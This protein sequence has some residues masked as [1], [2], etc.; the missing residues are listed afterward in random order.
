MA[1]LQCICRSPYFAICDVAHPHPACDL[2]LTHASKTCS[3]VL[4]PKPVWCGLV[5]KCSSYVRHLKQSLAYAGRNTRDVECKHKWHAHMNM[6][7]QLAYWAVPYCPIQKD[8]CVIWRIMK[9]CGAIKLGTSPKHAHTC[10]ATHV[11]WHVSCGTD[12]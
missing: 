3:R 8:L 4:G 9:T 5:I 6:C 10:I 7:V 2:H 11:V 1:S 12:P